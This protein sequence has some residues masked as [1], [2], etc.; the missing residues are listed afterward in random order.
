MRRR[1]RIPWLEAFAALAALSLARCGG[2]PAA[3]S[4]QRQGPLGAV[5]VRVN[6]KNVIRVSDTNATL[7]VVVSPLM[8]GTSP[9][10]D[11]IFT[12]L[13]NLQCN[14]I[15]YVPW[16]P[17]PKLS[18]AELQPPENG[19]TSWDF[20]LI[21]PFSEDFAQAAEGQSA[22]WNFSTIPQWM[23]K[24]P[25]SISYPANPDQI[26]WTYEQGAE[27][28]D[29]SM[30]EVANYYARLVSWY[31]KGGFKDEYGHQHASGHHYNFDYWEVLNEVDLE[32][33]MTPQFY[34]VLYD[35]IV[36]AIRNVDPKMKFVA[37][38]LAGAVAEP[39]F[40]EYFLN[41]KNHKPGIP[42][43]M[44]SYHFYAVPTRAQT[45]DDWQYT[46]FDQ[47]DG[48]L[49]AVRYIQ[50]VRQRLSP[51]TQTTVDEAG[52][53]LPGD[54]LEILQSLESEPQPSPEVRSLIDVYR[55]AT[56]YTGPADKI[57]SAIKPIPAVYWNACSAVYAYLY[58]Q[59]SL[60]GIEGVG[61]SA[62]AQLPGFFPSVT[63]LDWNS[64][65]PNPR[66]WVL[67]LLRDNFGP[68]DKLVA[69]FASGPYVYAQA[70]AMP[71]GRHKLL[72]VNKRD[73]ELDVSIAGMSSGEEAYVDQ[74]TGSQPPASA[75]V[76]GGNVT[77]RA[78]AVAVVTLPQ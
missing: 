4:R 44:I 17:Y 12:A 42:L 76:S 28:R 10:H 41:H 35:A 66:Y 11:R 50:T 6:W 43:D 40:F 55:A 34:T 24:T 20:S 59:L 56:G 1:A 25:E 58:G 9:I 65:Q 8:S 75:H 23:W 62:L 14:L 67:K 15:R 68:G 38:A 19:K 61:E 31:T 71:G 49:N 39:S 69:T 57:R 45:P 53:F 2:R 52:C 54:M 27:L 73:R 36:A 7:Q 33:H 29:P 47:A 60:Q 72:L 16:L 13:R 78:F 32:H 64:G 3:P 48:F 37:M 18:V 51:K 46:F 26:T 5:Q 21:D 70:F 74:T 30:K 77:L 22:I 63:M